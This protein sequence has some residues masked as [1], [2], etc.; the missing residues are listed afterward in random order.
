ML[1]VHILLVHNRYQQFG[2]EDAVFEAERNLLAAH[3]HELVVYER[4]NTEI[5]SSVLSKLSAARRTL[6]ASDSAAALSA[7]IRRHRPELAHF[8]NTFPLISPSAYAAC[9]DA[10]VPVVQNVQ[11]YRLICP[12][13]SLFRDGHVCEECVGRRAPWPGVV[14]RCYQRSVAGTATVAAMLTLHRELGTWDRRIDLYVAASEFMRRK[15]IQGGLPA[16]RVA[17]KPNFL[18]D[19]PGPRSQPGEYALFVGRLS[20]EKGLSTLLEAWKQLP[21]VP[22]KI[23]GTGPL[24]GW[25]RDTIAALNRRDIELCGFL[26]LSEVYELMAGARFLVVPSTWYEGFPTAIV[27]ALAR[28][29]PVLASNIGG[30][31]ETIDDGIS[32]VLFE[33]GNANA[34]TAEARWLWEHPHHTE[35]MGRAARA[36]FEREFSASRN[37]ELLMALYARVLERQP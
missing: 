36:R 10:G 12:A 28:G 26:Q 23:A 11:N 32:G 37:Y 13:A 30:L 22:L 25:C 29:V 15:L 24:L 1:S 16:Q 2:G 7:L 20:P 3:G 34:L 8:T 5:G 17:A 19:D 14:H 9:G 35:H 31:P 18:Q 4:S 27:Q 21:N 6:W 33:A